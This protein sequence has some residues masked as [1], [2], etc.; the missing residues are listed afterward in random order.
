MEPVLESNTYVGGCLCG[1]LRF[2][3]SGPPNRVTHCHCFMCRR[4]TGAAVATFA[5]FRTG[6]SFRGSKGKAAVYRASATVKRSFCRRCGTPLAYEADF[7]ESEI[8]LAISA[9]DEP[10]RLPPGSH[11][12]VAQKI[13]WFDTADD[14]PRYRHADPDARTKKPPP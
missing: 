9:F 12:H 10:D 14:L 8:Y 11:V 1:R 3:V 7:Y 4:Q 6:G 13:A 5:G 2:E